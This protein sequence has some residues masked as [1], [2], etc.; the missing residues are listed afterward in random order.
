MRVA[1][2]WFEHETVGD[3]IVRIIEPNVDPFLQANL[4]L[5]R[6]R[7]RDVLIDAGL[8]LASLTD[9]LP[10][11]FQRRVLAVATHRHFDHVGGLREF[12]AVAVHRADA[13]AVASGEI[14]ASLVIEDYP[15]E[16]LS[17]YEP[18]Q[19]LL[20]ALP[21]EGFEP[22]AYRV[23]PVMPTVLLDEGDVL[24]L[25]ERKLEVLH[26]PGHTPGEIGL[27]ED[28][29]GTLFSG[30]CVYESGVL[31]D[32]LPESNID[33]YVASMERLRDLSVSIVQG[34]HDGPFG[35]RRLL[36]LIDEYVRR[37]AR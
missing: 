15:P 34:G 4:Y 18:P 17:G 29:T 9:E 22:A 14:F 1:E 28:E 35:R 32:E 8:G 13:E 10:E 26:L 5:V 21:Y 11:L 20:T 2:R 16:E 23:E 27:W 37:R 12:G 19:T 24:D 7:D 3:G 6:G 31:L 36:E 30:D 33:D 25:G